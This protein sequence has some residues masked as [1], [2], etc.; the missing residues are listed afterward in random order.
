MSIFTILFFYAALYLV[1]FI[2]FGSLYSSRMQE[3]NRL[4]KLVKTGKFNNDQLQ[5]KIN[6][7]LISASKIKRR[8]WF[9]FVALLAVHLF[10]ILLTFNA[11][12]LYVF[13]LVSCVACLLLLL[14]VYWLKG[15]GTI[16]GNA[17]FNSNGM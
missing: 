15:S 13:A 2:V 5:S 9:T 7:Y 10:V 4:N 12:F 1:A 11:F 8:G 16:D 14:V 17:R 6:D 3:M